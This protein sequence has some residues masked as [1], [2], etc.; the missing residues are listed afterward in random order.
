LNPPNIH[1]ISKDPAQILENVKCFT[2]KYSSSKGEFPLPKKAKK[3]VAK[4]KV[5]RRVLKKRAPAKKKV[6]PAPK[7]TPPVETPS[8]PPPVE[9]P[10]APVE[11]QPGQPTI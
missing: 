1:A 3:K 6:V 2:R 7:P 8:L 11:T 4:K 9:T 10:S 5:K